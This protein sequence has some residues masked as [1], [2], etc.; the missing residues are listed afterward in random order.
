MQSCTGRSYRGTTCFRPRPGSR[1]HSFALLRGVRQ[2][3]VGRVPFLPAARKLHN[4]AAAVHFHLPALSEKP[5]LR[6]YLFVIAFSFPYL[7]YVDLI[8][9][10]KL[11]IVKR[12]SRYVLFLRSY[13]RL[14]FLCKQKYSRYYK[15]KSDKVKRCEFLT[16]PKKRDN[17]TRYRLDACYNACLHRAYIGYCLKV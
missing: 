11:P 9:S 3:L 7:L 16:Q 15:H 14:L 13:S 4:S 8:L 2:G 5:F 17:G 12:N 10:Q 1:A 6:C